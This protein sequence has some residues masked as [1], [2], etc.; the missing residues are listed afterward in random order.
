MPNAANILPSLANVD[1]DP[2][3]T[4]SLT[5]QSGFAGLAWDK[6]K[7]PGGLHTLD[8][9]VGTRSSRAASRCSPRCA[10]RWA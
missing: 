4:H 5:W 3:R 2:G 9:P 1:F 8:G 10:T 6:E 7:V